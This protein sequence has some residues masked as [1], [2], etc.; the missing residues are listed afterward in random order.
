METLWI[1]YTAWQIFNTPP[2]APETAESAWQQ[3]VAE[4]AYRPDDHSARADFVAKWQ[5]AHETDDADEWEAVDGL[6]P[7]K[8]DPPHGQ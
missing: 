7:R 6:P 8:G 3:A 1:E 5:A 4:G 2:E